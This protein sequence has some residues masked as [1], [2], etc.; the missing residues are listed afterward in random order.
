M[1]KKMRKFLSIIILSLYYILSFQNAYANEITNSLPRFVTIKSN[2]VNARSGPGSSYKI[3]WVFVSK[4][5][6][7]KIIAEFEQWRK[8]EDIEGKGGWIH[9][10]VLS[11]KRSVIIIGN[12]IEK[13]YSSS[14]VS[15]R[16]V[17]K[18]EPGLRCLFDKCDANW[19]KI[20]CQGHK[21]WIE[22]K[23]LWGILDSDYN[24]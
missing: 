23:K 3:E 11:P 9:S 7:V 15:S 13:L 5:E 12:N 19:C 14:K 24:L 8:V 22:S 2:Q 17:A 16:I 4:G 21:G 6:P 1:Q 10:S 20:K 18:L